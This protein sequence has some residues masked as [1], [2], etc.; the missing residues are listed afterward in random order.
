MSLSLLGHGEVQA[1]RKAQ[2]KVAGEE[3]SMDREDPSRQC[4][5]R[6]MVYFVI[7][8]HHD[9]TLTELLSAEKEEAENSERQ[10]YNLLW[11]IVESRKKRAW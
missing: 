8:T 11:L 9:C 5:T 10:T 7:N 6:F 4:E 2:R 1:N 3:S